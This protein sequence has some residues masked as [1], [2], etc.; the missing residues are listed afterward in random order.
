MREGQRIKFS[1]LGNWKIAPEIIAQLEPTLKESYRQ[2]QRNFGHK[3]ERIVKNHILNEDL[4]WVELADSTVKRK[5]SMQI[6]IDSKDYYDAIRVQSEGPYQIQV[7]VKEGATNTKGQDIG[8]YA[9][10]NEYGHVFGEGKR[11]VP[12]RPLWNPSWREMG[13][14]EGM[15]QEVI[16]TFNRVSK[17][18][19]I[20][21]YFEVIKTRTRRLK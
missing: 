10:I 20:R 14:K 21:Q 1:L 2:A 13:G 3:L 17:L 6:Y 19:G 18:K 4:E 12:A 8:M 16:A 9:A 11:K 5:K 15:A 7:G